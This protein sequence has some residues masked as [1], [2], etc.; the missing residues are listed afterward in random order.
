MSLYFVFFFVEGVFIFL[1]TFF[2][3]FF[4]VLPQTQHGHISL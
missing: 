1:S 4:G 2:F 3:V